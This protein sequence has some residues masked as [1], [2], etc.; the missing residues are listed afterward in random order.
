[1]QN[2][3]YFRLELEFISYKMFLC[4]IYELVLATQKPSEFPIRVGPL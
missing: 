2:L 3:Q 1:M 4:M